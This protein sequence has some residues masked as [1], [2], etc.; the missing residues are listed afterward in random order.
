[1]SPSSA[2]FGISRDLKIPNTESYISHGDCLLELAC[3]ANFT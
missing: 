2:H 1:M 3:K